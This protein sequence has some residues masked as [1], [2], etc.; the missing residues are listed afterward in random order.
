MVRAAEE[1]F[2][3][4]LAGGT[5]GKVPVCPFSLHNRRIPQNGSG[6]VGEKNGGCP[7]GF[8]SGIMVVQR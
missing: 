1:K 7:L 3:F 5:I 4:S 8:A 2:Y 6:W